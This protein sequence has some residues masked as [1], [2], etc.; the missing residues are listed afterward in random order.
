MYASNGQATASAKL[1]PLD[2]TQCGNTTYLNPT[3]V[4]VVL[5]PVDEGILVIRRSDTGKLALPGG[6]LE[7]G[8]SWQEGIA[9]ELYE[10]TGIRISSQEI[11]LYDAKSTQNGSLILLFGLAAACTLAALPPFVANIETTEMVVLNEAET[12]A[13]P[14]HTQV[15]N[16]F[17][18]EKALNPS[19]IP[20]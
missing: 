11:A 18:S 13:F 4:G 15:L 12:L 17:F 10:E 8:E 6:Y 19:N 7:H 5:L 20:S 3:V 1:K 9:R 16:R 2:C 14:L